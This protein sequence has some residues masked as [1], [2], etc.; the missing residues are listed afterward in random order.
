MRENILRKKEF[1]NEYN[2]NKHQI[3]TF[4]NKKW[5]L[6]QL[7]RIYTFEL[8]DNKKIDDL[9]KKIEREKKLNDDDLE[10]FLH[11]IDLLQEK[12][13]SQLG[14][15]SELVDHLIESKI[16]NEII[17]KKCKEEYELK[18]KMN[19]QNFRY[20]L[21]CLHELQRKRIFETGVVPMGFLPSDPT[22]VDEKIDSLQRQNERQNRY[23]LFDEYALYYDLIKKQTIDLDFDQ[24]IREKQYVD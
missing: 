16:G 24:H 19:D 5:S 10:F 11:S 1:V 9:R 8:T 2:L 20:L 3:S 17:L 6:N 14:N 22:K 12:I 23:I 21:Y 4:R 7:G 15:Q 13:E 18:G